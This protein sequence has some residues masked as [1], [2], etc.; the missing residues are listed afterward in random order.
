MLSSDISR[1]GGKVLVVSSR[2]GLG[3]TGTHHLAF[4]RRSSAAAGGSLGGS[5]PQ[6][7]RG[8]NA[9]FSETFLPLST[10]PLFSVAHFSS[11]S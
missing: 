3:A 1:R 7:V 9:E 5:V 8:Q 6:Q 4:S 11:Q 10:D 2:L